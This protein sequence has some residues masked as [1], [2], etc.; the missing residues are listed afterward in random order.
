M[1]PS[2]FGQRNA[3]RQ[4]E[5]EVGT[6]CAGDSTVDPHPMVWGSS[7]AAATVGTALWQQITSPASC[8]CSFRP[9]FP[10]LPTLITV[11]YSWLVPS[12]GWACS[13]ELFLSLPKCRQSIRGQGSKYLRVLHSTAPRCNRGCG[14][15]RGVKCRWES[16][17]DKLRE[18]LPGAGVRNCV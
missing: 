2:I 16:F 13:K 12:K 9:D 8:S 10:A 1:R 5:Q 6:S 15:W 4:G 18:I 11:F 3:G 14:S 7:L 17:V